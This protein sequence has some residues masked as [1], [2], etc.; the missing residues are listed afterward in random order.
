MIDRNRERE[1]EKWTIWSKGTI[2]NGQCSLQI[3][4]RATNDYQVL[5]L[6]THDSLK[7]MDIQ[8]VFSRKL[9]YFNMYK[10]EWK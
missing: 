7:W 1:I 2:Y 4:A 5:E 8:V 3:V 10:I 6:L 9:K